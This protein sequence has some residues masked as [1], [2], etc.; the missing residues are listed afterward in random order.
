[1]KLMRTWGNNLGN[2]IGN[3]LYKGIEVLHY[4]EYWP[5]ILLLRRQGYFSYMIHEKMWWKKRKISFIIALIAC[6]IHVTLSLLFFSQSKAD[7][8]WWFRVC[9][10]F[11]SISYSSSLIGRTNML[12]THGVKMCE[13]E[14]KRGC[15]EEKTESQHMLFNIHGRKLLSRR[16]D[17]SKVNRYF[18]QITVG[19]FHRTVNGVYTTPTLT[20]TVNNSDSFIPG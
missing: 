14:I 20:Q 7:M 4:D 6:H 17:F 10:L 8:C 19:Q 13:Q 2:Y 9:V 1:M 11:H 16:N 18:Q 12:W 5:G 3:V 15:G